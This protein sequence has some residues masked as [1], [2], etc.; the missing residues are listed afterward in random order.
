MK[1]TDAEI[2][3]YKDTLSVAQDKYNAGIA[4]GL[5]LDDVSLGYQVSLFNQK[6]AI[7]DYILAQAGFDKA[8]G[9]I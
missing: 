3:A 7:Y 9:G 6:Q 5:D 1:S 4:S 8:T 2:A